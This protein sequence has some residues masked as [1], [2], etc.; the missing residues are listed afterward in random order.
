MW[1]YLLA[2]ESQLCHVRA[3][4][5]PGSEHDVRKKKKLIIGVRAMCN[6]IRTAQMF[7][8]FRPPISVVKKLKLK[9]SNPNRGIFIIRNVIKSILLPGPQ[10]IIVFRLI[11]LVLLCLMQHSRR[12]QGNLT[13]VL[14]RYILIIIR[15]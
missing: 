4:M 1:V 6:T 9:T 15:I 11:K 8:G 5:M 12:M 7:V 13:L 3:G 10:T 14:L 2:L